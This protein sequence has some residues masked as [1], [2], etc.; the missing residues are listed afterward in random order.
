MTVLHEVGDEVQGDRIVC[1]YRKCG[2]QVLFH[3]TGG[4]RGIQ[5]T[6][7]GLPARAVVDKEFEPVRK[8]GSP[9]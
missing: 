6:I 8:G 3:M 5:M 1:Y 2:R 4:H 9:V 7:R